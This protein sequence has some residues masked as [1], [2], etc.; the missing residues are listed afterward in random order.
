MQTHRRIG[1]NV[2]T[3]VGRVLAAALFL[4]SAVSKPFA[5]E[6]ALDEIASYGLPRAW[7]VLAP[8]LALQLF[9]GLLLVLG[10]YTRLAAAALLAFMVPA[11]FYI[12]GFYRYSGAEFDH[13]LLG[14]FQ[15]LTMSS[16][17]VLLLVTGPGRWSLDAKFGIELG[18]TA[19]GA[20]RVDGR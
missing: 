15:N 2:A 16:G 14:F 7:W 4:L 18:E 5:W 19:K 3:L 6:A 13:H 20:G 9:G 17:L 12:H 11:T 8:A 1:L 10:L